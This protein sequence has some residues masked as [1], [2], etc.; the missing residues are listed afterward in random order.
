MRK[1]HI[2]Y[3]VPGMK[4]GKTIYGDN[5][6]VLLK[7]G[8]EIS[9]GYIIRLKNKGYTRIY[10][11]DEETADIEIKDPISDKIRSM[12]TKDILKTFKMTQSS[13]TNIEAHTTE[14]VIKSINTPKIKAT[15]QGNHVFKQLC[16]N[17]NSFLDEIMGQDILSGLNS[18]K[19]FDNYTYEHSIDS[20]VVSLII[21][22]RLNLNK[23]KL[24]QIAVGEFLHDIGKIFIDE[25]IINKPGKLTPEEFETIKQHP[26][27]GYELLKDVEDV[28]GVS[29]HVPYQHHERQDGKGYP[30]GLKGTNKIDQGDMGY[31]DRDKLILIAEIAAI[32]DFYDACIS[33]RPYRKGLP[34]DLV[35]ELIKNGAGVQFNR[36][37]VEC[38]LTVMPKY[39]VGYDIK[40]KDG[41]YKGFTGIVVSVNITQLSK[42]KIR[43]LGDDKKNKIQP[44]EID[45]SANIAAID[46][47]CIY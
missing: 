8:V 13:I 24:K 6:E 27:F 47:E 44:V 42:P 33:D 26:T 30:R 18:I 38:F 14:S 41:V 2:N 43:L 7:K 39:P 25:K 34:P 35:Y 11:D 31:V 1:I 32:A 5:Y 3:A 36:E 4:L 16:S 40:I 37:I 10:I 20:A 21:A 9:E 28:G 22:K 45:L 19:S 12:A 17:I 15:F 46:M 29:A 23:Q